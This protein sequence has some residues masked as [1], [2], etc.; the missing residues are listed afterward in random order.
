MTGTLQRRKRRHAHSSDTATPGIQRVCFYC[1]V[2]T[3]EQADQ[4]TVELQLDYLRSRFRADFEGTGP[5][6]MVMV[7]EFVDEGWSGAIPFAERP[8]G[9]RAME[10]ARNHQYDVLALYK[11]DRL[12]RKASVLLQAHEDLE[13]FDVAITSAT[14]PFDTRPGPMQA[15][16]TFVFQLLGSIA[17][18][19]RATIETR[20]MGGKLRVAKEGE[21][22]NGVVPFGYMVT[23]AGLLV[24]NTAIV[25]E[26][27]VTEAALVEQLFDRIAAGE[28]TYALADWLVE[29]GVDSPRRWYNKEQKRVTVAPVAAPWSNRRV[30]ETIRNE[31]Y[32]GER[33]LSFGM[34]EHTQQVPPIVTTEVWDS[35]NE[36][37]K[38][39]NAWKGDRTDTYV[40]LLS[41]KLR[42]GLCGLM[43]TGGAANG[44]FYYKCNG[45]KKRHGGRCTARMLRAEK[46]EAAVWADMAWRVR[47]PAAGL[48]QA[49][50]KLR[51]RQSE[52]V[53]Q[54]DQRAALRQERATLESV[55]LHLRHEL[56]NGLRPFAEVEEDL[57]ANAAAIARK[58]ERLA[59][60]DV[61]LAVTSDMER[62]FAAALPLLRQ[63][64]DE[65]DAIEAEG[66]RL[67]MR[68]IMQRLVQRVSIEDAHASLPDLTVDYTFALGTSSVRDLTNIQTVV[69]MDPDKTSGRKAS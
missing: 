56:T 53:D 29:L 54:S 34:A 68:T 65:L 52:S 51:E 44:Y 11:V 30:W 46:L 7:E 8:A 19:E 69:I 33:L 5:V 20:T 14:E 4:N 31:T 64:A 59:Q 67:K 37:M 22:V 28:S 42:C 60:L 25:P 23:P 9:A 62:N 18:L 27:G 17:Q 35:A 24:P 12:G 61:S 39:R 10:A 16:G 26:L 43:Y 2:S 48:Q 55:R 32:K 66:D 50:N 45:V 40:Y 36:K 49:Q 57:A 21:F 58:D 63:I 47:N 6:P 41:R 3:D 1:R 13:H 15:F 38:D